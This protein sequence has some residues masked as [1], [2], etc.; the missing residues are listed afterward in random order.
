MTQWVPESA[1]NRTGSA[2]AWQL[3][4]E[5]AMAPICVGQL[6]QLCLCPNKI[7]EFAAGLC[8]I[9]CRRC[10][11]SLQESTSKDHRY[12]LHDGWYKL[13]TNWSTGLLP[14]SSTCSAGHLQTSIA[15]AQWLKFPAKA[16]ENGA[17]NIAASGCQWQHDTH[18][19]QHASQQP[20]SRGVQDAPQA[21]CRA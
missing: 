21:V 17:C 18:D 19:R 3:N 4:Q 12:W 8:A 7:V 9:L 15:S 11:F 1:P 10:S 2:S 5:K 20:H 14:Y 16:A 6:C 13:I